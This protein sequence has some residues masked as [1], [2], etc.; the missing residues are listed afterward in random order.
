[1]SK[2]TTWDDSH[3]KIKY[4]KTNSSL[5]IGDHYHNSHEI[6]FVTQGETEFK[7]SNKK[8]LS[9]ENSIIFINNF[10][11]HKN[12]HSLFDGNLTPQLLCENLSVM[13]DMEI[14]PGKTLLFF[15]EIQTCIP[16]ISSLRFF[17]EKMPECPAI[18]GGGFH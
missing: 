13:F 7:I 15:D 14:I 10:E 4:G 11:E 18:Y 1:M 9:S 6:V 12:V 17:Y 8:Y 16:A 3:F 2:N 5:E